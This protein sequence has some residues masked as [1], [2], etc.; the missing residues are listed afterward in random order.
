MGGGKQV[1]MESHLTCGS[2]TVNKG[3][4]QRLKACQVITVDMAQEACER[5]SVTRVRAKVVDANLRKLGYDAFE[6]GH[7]AVGHGMA[8]VGRAGACNGEQCAGPGHAEKRDTGIDR[9]R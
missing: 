4:P 7:L 1:G 5:G 6:G 9:M 2:R 3:C 8:A